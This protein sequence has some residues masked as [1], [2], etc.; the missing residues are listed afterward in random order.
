MRFPGGQIM[1]RVKL[2]Y[3]LLLSGAGLVAPIIVQADSISGHLGLVLA[4]TDSASVYIKR[5]KDWIDLK[6][7]RRARREFSMAINIDPKNVAARYETAY[8]YYLQNNYYLAIK[9]LHKIQ[10]FAP[11]YKDAAHLMDKIRAK[12]YQR[13][14]SSDDD[15]QSEGLRITEATLSPAAAPYLKKVMRGGNKYNA[16]KAA[17]LLARI[18]PQKAKQ[19][20][21]TL[22]KNSN[23]S[24]QYWAAEKLW[25]MDRYQPAAAILSQ[26]YGN[27]F[28]SY[29]DFTTAD[30]GKKL[31]GLG[32]EYA[33]PIFLAALRNSTS[34]RDAKL[35]YVLKVLMQ[36]RVKEVTPTLINTL[37]EQFANDHYKYTV[38]RR[39]D[40]YIHSLVTLRAKKA[41]PVL[42]KGLSIL[43]SCVIQ[44]RCYGDSV[45]GYL[46]ASA[47]LD[48]Q[49]WKKFDYKYSYGVSE[50]EK[51]LNRF[52]CFKDSQT[53]CHTKTYG[54]DE[55]SPNV[56]RVHSLANFLGKC[57]SLGTCKKGYNLE[58]DRSYIT[59]HGPKKVDYVVSVKDTR[60]YKIAGQVK[61]ALRATYD[62][63][64]AWEIT[65]VKS[66]TI[67]GVSQNV[68]ES[69]CR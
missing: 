36:H 3:I 33:K 2:L 27:I 46:A 17:K 61:L 67:P 1:T 52:K 39:N 34:Y 21:I 51:T 66:I 57:N 58:S 9:W 13:L 4:Q 63:D 8:T 25:D 49:N 47:V 11:D 16:L 43:I 62:S 26:K 37:K 60:H 10:A 29:E 41:V 55:T 54:I 65:N 38:F 5:G 23:T 18:D 24:I 19:V 50:F 45:P 42:K 30:A 68:L 53:G 22:L 56:C 40:K 12:G 44:T 7:Y 31:L 6:N 14:A 48:G 15:T 35:F 32:F 59:I 69:A 20:W 64:R 28:L